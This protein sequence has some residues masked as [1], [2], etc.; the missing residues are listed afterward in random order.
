MKMTAGLAGG[1]ARTAHLRRVRADHVRSGRPSPRPGRRRRRRR[2]LLE[3]HPRPVHPRSRVDLPELRRP[4][5]LPA[6]GPRRARRSSPAPRSGPR[7]PAT[8][9]SPGRTSRRSWPAPLGPTCRKEDLGLIGGATEGVNVIVNGLALKKGDEVITSTHEH[10]AVHSA[11]LNRMQRD[12]IV[13]PPASIRTSRARQGNV[14]RI[15]RLINAADAPRHHEPRHLHDR[16]ASS[17]AKE[18]AALARSKSIW[19]ALDGAQAP[20]NAPFDIVDIRASIS[21]PAAPTSG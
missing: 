19:F 4:R 11:L 21:T 12:G 15:A 9:R 6:A 7:A 1:I 18:I 5:L 14:D 10:V 3:A 20:V 8:T 13:D 17:A 2:V 16:P